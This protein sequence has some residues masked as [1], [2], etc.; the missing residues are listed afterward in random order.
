M[1]LEIKDL[2]ELRERLERL[3]VEAVMFCVF[4]CGEQL[5][6][7]WNQATLNSILAE[8]DGWKP[9][10]KLRHA[11]ALMAADP[12][13]AFLSIEEAYGLEHLADKIPPGFTPAPVPDRTAFELL[14]VDGLDDYRLCCV[15]D[16]ATSCLLYA[17][18]GELPRECRAPCWPTSWKGPSNA[19]TAGSCSC[20][21][22]LGGRR[23]GWPERSAHPP[24]RR[25]ARYADASGCPLTLMLVPCWVCWPTVK[26]AVA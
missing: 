12:V 25:P 19:S 4:I 10:A 18:V 7:S 13:T 5:G 9:T 8:L 20:R 6:S 14:N 3:R 23:T 24:I 11:P 17:R 15:E 26:S 2:S 21:N 16:D 1:P 22:R